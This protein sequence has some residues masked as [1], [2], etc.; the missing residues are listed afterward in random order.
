MCIDG[1]EGYLRACELRCLLTTPLHSVTQTL[2]LWG[3][4]PHVLQVNG[5][6]FSGHSVGYVSFRSAF[7]ELLTSR[8]VPTVRL[9]LTGF[10]EIHGLLY[11]RCALQHFLTRPLA[12]LVLYTEHICV[13]T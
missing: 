9:V 10:R 3:F 12:I 13:V 1:E 5:L 11:S 7:L 6:M 2:F 4:I 8:G